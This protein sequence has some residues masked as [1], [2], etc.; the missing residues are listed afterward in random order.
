ME[1]R[2]RP[3]PQR[4]DPAGASP[5]EPSGGGAPWFVLGMVLVALVCL[6]VGCLRHGSDWKRILVA[7]GYLVTG[8]G[9]VAIGLLELEWL[10]RVIGFVDGI[11]S[12]LVQWFWTSW[13]GSLSDSELVGRRGA[14]MIWVVLGFP[15]FVWGC[16]KALGVIGI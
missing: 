13:C 4:A 8:L 14:A 15:I 9:F 7:G 10:E 16:L 3:K 1:T 6:F 12:G 11:V 5:T 2:G